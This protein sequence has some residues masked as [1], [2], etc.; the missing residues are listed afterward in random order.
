MPMSNV[1]FLFQF[2]FIYSYFLIVPID[3]LDFFLPDNCAIKLLFFPF[4]LSI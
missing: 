4:Y 1:N 3:I 2:I